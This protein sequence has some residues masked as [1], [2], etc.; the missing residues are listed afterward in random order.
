[1][2]IVL[3]LEMQDSVRTNLRFESL[4]NEY[5]SQTHLLPPVHRLQFESLVN[6]YGSQTMSN[7][8]IFKDAV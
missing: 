1:M 7:D 2:I 4:V 5:G 8:N 6:E 3:S